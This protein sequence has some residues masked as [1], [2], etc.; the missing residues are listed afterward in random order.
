MFSDLG[1]YTYSKMEIYYKR[2]IKIHNLIP[3]GCGSVG[4]AGWVSGKSSRVRSP[5]NTSFGRGKEP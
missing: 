2:V 1:T 4:D 3:N 5:L